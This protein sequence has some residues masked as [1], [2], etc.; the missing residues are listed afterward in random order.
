[1]L[2]KTQL[3]VVKQFE[4][5][6]RVCDV[7]QLMDLQPTVTCRPRSALRTDC[8]GACDSKPGVRVHES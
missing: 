2:N 6:T 1:M 4:M 3:S 7:V 8:I 5:E